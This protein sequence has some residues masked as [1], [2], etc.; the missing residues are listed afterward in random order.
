MSEADIL[1]Q[2]N[3]LNSKAANKGPQIFPSAPKACDMAVYAA[4]FLG[5]MIST[6][7]MADIVNMPAAPTPWTVRA[8]TSWRVHMLVAAMMAPMM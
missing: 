2:L 3:L 1:T 4:L 6:M 7:T 5:G 8:A